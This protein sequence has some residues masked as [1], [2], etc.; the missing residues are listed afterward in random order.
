M[1]GTDVHQRLGFLITSLDGG[2]AERVVSTLSEALV[3]RRR[4]LLLLEDEMVYPF[5]GDVHVLDVPILDNRSRYEKLW[6]MFRAVAALR[7]ARQRLQLD[8][9]VSFLTW[10][11]LF[12]ILSAT[13]DRTIISVRNNPSRAL[14]GP[15]APVL[16]TLIRTLYPRADHIVAISQDVRRDLIE[17]FRVDPS[18]IST[19]YNPIRVDRVQRRATDSLP[20]PLAS[21]PDHPTIITVGRLAIQ[22]GHW[23]L[24]RAFRRVRDQFDAGRLVILGVGPFR[25]YLIGLARNLQLT[26]WAHDEPND[27]PPLDHDVIFW[28]FDDNPFPIVSACDVFAFPSLWEGLGNVLLE[29]LACGLPVAS[30]DCRSGPREIL[31]PQTPL[32]Q[33]ID[34]PEWAEY[35]VLLPVCDGQRYDHTAPLTDG[36]RIWADVLSRLLANPPLRR[37]YARRGQHRAADFHIDH[38]SDQWR[39]LLD[40]TA[41]R[42]CPTGT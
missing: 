4:S 24:V 27:A 35:G 31:A 5:D 39:R 30:A 28:G 41:I 11:N 18:Q 20:A 21:L 23:H 22:K 32:H 14:R 34:H 29:S 12:N 2:G 37:R 13:G 15:F 16:K 26:V 7:G 9:C 36:E 33:Q 19:I 38:I 6:N 1:I 17:S 10:P 40:D 3:E 8:V 42:R 25:D